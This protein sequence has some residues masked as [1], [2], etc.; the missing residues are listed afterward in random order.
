MNRPFLRPAYSGLGMT[1]IGNRPRTQVKSLK[2]SIAKL[3]AMTF[4]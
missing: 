2:K 4:K 1:T 3:E